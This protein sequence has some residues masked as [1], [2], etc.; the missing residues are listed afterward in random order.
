MRGGAY[1]RC[2]QIRQANAAIIITVG[3]KMATKLLLG[4]AGIAKLGAAYLISA[5]RTVEIIR[6]LETNPILLP[7]LI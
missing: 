5:A 1:E 6:T 4:V 7:I 3:V 2:R